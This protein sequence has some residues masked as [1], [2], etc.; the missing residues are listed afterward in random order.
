M[1]TKHLDAVAYQ[2]YT[3]KH[4]EFLDKMCLCCGIRFKQVDGTC[5]QCKKDK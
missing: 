5:K 2:E 3:K 1:N 4:L